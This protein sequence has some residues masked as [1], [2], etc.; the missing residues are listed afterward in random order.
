MFKGKGISYMAFDKQRPLDEVFRMAKQN[1]FD[2]VEVRVLES[3][4]L[5]PQSTLDECR[6]VLEM[7]HEASIEL[8]SMTHNFG[9][10][11]P[12]ITTSE[13]KRGAAIEH[14]TK[15]LHIAKNLGIDAFLLVPGA[16][17]STSIEPPAVPY[18]VAYDA[19][20]AALQELKAVAEATGVAIAVENVWNKF[21]LSPLEFRDFLDKVG[22]PRVGCYFDVGNVL[23]N[24]YPEQWITIL[25]SRIVRVHF[26]DFDSKIGGM[27]GFCDLLAGDADYPAVMDA[28]RTIDY[29]GWVTAEFFNCESDL[30]KISQAMDEIFKL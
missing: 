23:V 29:N 30:K 19:A 21:L 12:L 5:T 25:G 8:P 7:A 22:S 2:A 28:L 15:I 6:R 27:E 9:P 17:G 18:D 3:G 24:G 13:E 4:L 26:K 20:L 10:Q 1:G 16:V 14:Y 11:F